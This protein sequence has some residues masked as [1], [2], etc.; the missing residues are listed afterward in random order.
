MTRG[1]AATVAAPTPL[2]GTA[3]SAGHAGPLVDCGKARALGDRRRN[4]GCRTRNR[5]PAI[6]RIFPH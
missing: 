2:R 4:A 3:A 5:R 6:T 1:I